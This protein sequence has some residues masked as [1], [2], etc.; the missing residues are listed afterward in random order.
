M[1]TLNLRNV[2]DELVRSLK[3]RA[4]QHGVTLK[5]WC[6]DILSKDVSTLPVRKLDLIVK[7]DL[8]KSDAEVAALIEEFE[9]PSICGF[10]AYN[11]E[12]GEFAVCGREKGHAKDKHGSWIKE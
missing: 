8:D 6:V 12:I 4:V 10:R 3:T 9:R 5:D 11:E 1:G 2:P 7:D